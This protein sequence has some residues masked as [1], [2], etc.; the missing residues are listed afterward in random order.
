ML[1]LTHLSFLLLGLSAGALGGIVGIGGG[2]ILVPVLVLL[3]HF[4]QHMAQGTSLAALLLPV[5]L[6]AVYIYHKNGYVHV[7]AALL[8][9]LGFLFGALAGAK[10]SVLVQTGLLQKLF[11]ILLVVIGTKFIFF[12]GK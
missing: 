8:I 12:P 7:T 11:G 5:G 1:N 4:E 9:A 2:V 10:I 6:F 3:F